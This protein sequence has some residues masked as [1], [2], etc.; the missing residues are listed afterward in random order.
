M[1]NTVS[2]PPRPPAELRWLIDA[3]GESATLALLELYGGTRLMVPRR[4]HRPKHGDPLATAIGLD[5]AVRLADVKG[6]E[7]F[8]V[9]L[10]RWWRIAM[11]KHQGLGT[12]AIARKLGLTERAVRKHAHAPVRE[13][14]E[15][16]HQDAQQALPW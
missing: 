2:P 4:Q 13:T 3:I 14:A 16:R 1:A 11:M 7:T 8:E 15:A 10:C 5:A 6:G 12:A 9:P